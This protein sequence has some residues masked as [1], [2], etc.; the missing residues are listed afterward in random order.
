MIKNYFKIALRNLFKNKGYTLI[1][2]GGLS[3]GITIVLLIGLWVHDELTFDKNHDNYDNISQV[4]M[5]RTRNGK[6]AIRYAMPYPLGDELREKYGEDFKHV[7]MSSFHGDNIL[8]FK[9]KNLSLRSGFMESGAL[10]MFSLDMIYG[11]WDG[12]NNPN[13]IVLS[14]T[15]S[16]AFFGTENP[17]G[18]T[19]KVNNEL[20]VLITGVYRDIA[21]NA[22]LKGLDF[23]VPWELYSM[24]YPWVKTAKDNN[25]WGNNSY[26][27]YVQ[28]ADGSTMT[29]VNGRIKDVIYNNVS[30]YSRKSQPELVLHPMKNWHLRSNWKNGVNAGGFIQYVWLFGIIGL[31]VLLLACINFMNLSTAQSEKRAKEVGIRKT[32]GSSKYQLINQF[33]SESFLVVLVAFIVA[34]IMVFMAMPWFN[35]LSHKQIVFPFKSVA[36]W[37]MSIAF[38]LFT[39]I[40]A[41]SYPALYLSSFRPVKV[42]KGTF[43]TGKSTTSFRKALVVVQFTVSVILVIGTI[44]VEKQVDYS[45]NRP[46]GYNMNSLIMIEKTTNNFDG[47]YNVIRNGLINSGAVVEM[48][49]SSSPLTDVWSTNGGFEWKDK[50]PNFITSIATNSV[51]HDYGKTVGWD[52]VQGRDFSR[53]FATDSTA[54]I[55]NEAAVKYMGLE[56]PVGKTIRWNNEEHQVIGVVKDILAVSPFE[57]VLQTVYMINYPNTNWIELKLNPERSITSSLSAVETIL[58]KHVANVPFDYQFVDDTFAEKFEAVERIRKL[59]TIFAIFAIFISCLGLFGLASY[60]AEQRTKEIGVRKVVGASVFN[61]WQLLSKDFVKLVMLSII[62]ATPLAYYGVIKWLNN[63]TYRTE[64]SWWVFAIAGIGAIG[65]TLF[66]V[67]F[68]ALKVAITN[69]IKSLR[70]E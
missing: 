45:K 37:V 30:E 50:D 28:V 47:K 8:S 70:T 64:V 11:N 41:G 29:S 35:Q 53:T 65:I 67:S 42:L 57:P 39:S 31:F 46:I 26:Q 23:I 15:A 52:L 21:D 6:K 7:V 54:F 59:S 5:W 4:M 9:D 24:L 10:S 32:V 17:L 44:V 69:P 36:F 16:K 20:N 14:E 2:V 38:I 25:L 34:I 43:K 19:M 13:S 3:L 49:E 33:L 66:T 27:L 56:D 61:L 58:S 68:Q 55:L 22:T 60:V 62:V 18:K 63:Y 51:S 40:L 12:L 48:A 1:N